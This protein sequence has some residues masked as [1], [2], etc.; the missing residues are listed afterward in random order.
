MTKSIL[1]ILVGHSTGGRIMPAALYRGCPKVLHN[2]LVMLKKKV[3]S[4]KGKN[5]HQAKIA[6]ACEKPAPVLSMSMAPHEI[7]YYHLFLPREQILC[8]LPL[9]VLM[10]RT[11]EESLLTDQAPM[12]EHASLQVL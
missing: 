2:V 8:V 4:D 6:A 1:F 3:G 5:K 10:S 9:S 7:E 11:A 12:H